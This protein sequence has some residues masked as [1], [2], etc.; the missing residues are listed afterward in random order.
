[1]PTA[2]VFGNLGDMWSN[3]RLKCELMVQTDPP[4][5]P[6]QMQPVRRIVGPSWGHP[7][8]V[9]ENG[10]LV[11]HPNVHSNASNLV[12][13]HLYSEFVPTELEHC[14]GKARANIPILGEVSDSRG[15]RSHCVGLG[16]NKVSHTVTLSRCVVSGHF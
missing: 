11:C 7:Q 15:F 2:S 16:D 13:I 10:G 5:L 8:R 6:A 3:L 4:H 1:M 9:E 14:R 12:R